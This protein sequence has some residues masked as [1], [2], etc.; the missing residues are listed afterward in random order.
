MFKSDVVSKFRDFPPTTD[1]DRFESSVPVEAGGVYLVGSFESEEIDQ[2]A[3]LGFRPRIG[4][5]KEVRVYQVWLRAY[6]VGGPID[7]ESGLA[8]HRTQEEPGTVPATEGDAETWLAPTTMV[9]TG[10]LRP[11]REVK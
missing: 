11:H 2:G 1:R 8:R 6:Q 3:T 4:T 10:S 9:A 5:S 7:E